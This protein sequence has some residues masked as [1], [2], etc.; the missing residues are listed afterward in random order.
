VRLHGR[1]DRTVKTLAMLVAP[2]CASPGGLG[3]SGLRCCDPQA[4]NVESMCAACDRLLVASGGE[5]EACQVER[6]DQLLERA[7]QLNLGSC[8]LTTCDS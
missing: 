3:N 8:Q 7:L 5:V 4:H 6:S 1:A 2:M